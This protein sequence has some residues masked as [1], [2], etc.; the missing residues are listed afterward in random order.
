MSEGTLAIVSVSILCM[1]L[2][3]IGGYLLYIKGK[4]ASFGLTPKPTPK[5][6]EGQKPQ[7]EGQTTTSQT[8]DGKNS[9]S[10]SSFTTSSG[11]NKCEAG[12]GDFVSFY[13]D[14][15]Y[16]GENWKLRCG[17]YPEAQKGLFANDAITS[18]KVPKGLK[19]FG[20]EHKHFGGKSVA[21]T[22]NVANLKNF[23]LNDKIS[24]IKVVHSSTPNPPNAMAASG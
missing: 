10:T 9:N 2:L 6:S 19:V 11:G 1:A 4:L 22:G 23:T 3:G 14:A 12:R 17:D 24:S 20:W 5:P 21:I 15:N 16:G 18:I 8:N 13:K 7:N